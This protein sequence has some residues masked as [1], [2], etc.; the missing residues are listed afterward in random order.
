MIRLHAHP[1]NPPSPLRNLDRQHT[2]SLRNR[3]Q[4]LTGEGGE[5]VG[6]ESNHKTL[7]KQDFGSGLGPDSIRPVDPDPDR[8]N[9]DPKPCK[10]ASINH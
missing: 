1:L 9:A 5:G 6:I 4:L 10:K 7:R 2:G 3:N 8:M